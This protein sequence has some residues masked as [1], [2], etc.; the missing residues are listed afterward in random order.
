MS[1]SIKALCGA[2]LFSTKQLLSSR[3]GSPLVDKMNNACTTVNFKLEQRNARMYVNFRAVR[4]FI[5]T[6]LQF[7]AN[8]DIT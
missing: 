3:L 4:T 1:L 6:V 5:Q 7:I 8:K 2:A